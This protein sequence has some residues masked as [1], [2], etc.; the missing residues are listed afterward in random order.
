MLMPII[1]LYRLCSDAETGVYHNPELLG[2]WEGSAAGSGAHNADTV[3]YV[4]SKEVEDCA[5]V[6]SYFH[7]LTAIFISSLCP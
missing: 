5:Q 7:Q 3:L 4:T 1:A 2:P 6:P